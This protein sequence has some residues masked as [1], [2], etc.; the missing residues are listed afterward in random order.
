MMPDDLELVFSTSND[1]VWWT[2]RI[3]ATGTCLLIPLKEGRVTITVENPAT[4][5]DASIT[6]RVKE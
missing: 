1:S 5:V 6:V 4:R 3:T 2:S